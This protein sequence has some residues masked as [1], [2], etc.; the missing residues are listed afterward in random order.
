[1]QVVHEMDYI[2]EKLRE[3]QEKKIE[4]LLPEL[5]ATN[6][7]EIGIYGSYARETYKA[8]SDVDMYVLYEKVPERIQKGE[9]YELAYEMGIDLLI[10][11]E[12]NFY[13]TD[14]VFCKNIMRD[15]KILWRQEKN[16]ES[17]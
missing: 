17:Q 10:A 16:N 6:P 14:S 1:M 5:I 2:K 11:S 7:I 4:E 12:E 3:K 13:K 8:T 15:R 9:L